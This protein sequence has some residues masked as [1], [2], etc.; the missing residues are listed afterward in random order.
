MPPQEMSKMMEMDDTRRF[1]TVTFDQLEWHA[2]AEKGTAVWDAEGA[3]GGDYDKVWIKSEGSR[4]NGQS[5]GA[6][7]EVL[8]D[9]T[10]SE[11]W[12]LQAGGRHDSGNGPARTWA[13]VGFEGVAPYWFN[14]QATIYLGEGGRTAVRL[15]TE[16]DLN[17]TQRLV[18][19]PKAEINLFGED[20]APRAIGS[21]LSDLQ[22]GARLR[23]EFRRELAPYA[24]VNWSRLFG[25]TADLARTTRHDANDVQLV[26]G[27][28]FWF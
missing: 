18:L 1:G 21:G 5:M 3:Y 15:K 17:L 25:S 19:Q 8:W 2:G 7:L 10:V 14:T 28:R 13:A 9:R 23:Y 27:L 6:S 11:W 16:Y 24:G 4:P 20:D 26:A 22:L 12:S